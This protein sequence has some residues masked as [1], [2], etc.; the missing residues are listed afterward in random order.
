MFYLLSFLWLVS[1]TGSLLFWL[2]FW[3]LKEYHI[4]RALA[5][6]QTAKG[7]RIFW[8]PFLLFKIILAFTFFPLIFKP[9]SSCQA[10]SGNLI[11][12][13]T[14]I[15]LYF[16]ESFKRFFFDF[17]G[18]KLKTPVFTK[19]VV[20]LIFVIFSFQIFFVYFFL[21]RFTFSFSL[22]VFDILTPLIVSFFVFFFQPLAKAAKMILI[23]RAKQKRERLSDLVVI[24]ITGSY[25][26]T[27]TKEFLAKI[28][29]EKFGNEKVGKTKGHQNSEVGISRCLLNDIR[30]EH[31]FFVVE[32]GA[33]NRGGIKLLCDIAKPQIGILT[34]ISEQ[35]L[36]TFGSQENIIKTKFELIEALPESGTA[37]LNG[38]NRYIR[39]KIGSFLEEGKIKV[40]NKIFYST[41]ER[42]DVWAEEVRVGKKDLS[43]RVVTREG[44]RT[45]IKAAL[46][47]R[48][49]VENLL[50]AICAACQLKM[51]LKEISQA[52]ERIRVEDAG[53]RLLEGRF[54]ILDSSYSANPDGVIADLD[55]LTL[56]EG[57]RAI[58]MPSLI[59]LGRAARQVHWRIGKKIGRVCDLAIIT[60]RDYF[61]EIRRAAVTEGMASDKILCLESPSGILEKLRDFQGS[62]DIILIEGRVG[63]AIIDE[64]E[65]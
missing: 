38:D 11:L 10:Y 39:S 47:G 19:K 27:S 42:L 8:N 6:F 50:G 18:G 4:G 44:R 5:H 55:Y 57:K 45:D 9:S 16:L 36:A 40:K 60:T 65:R 43:F 61:E 30:P 7:S 31:K 29:S 46:I 34:G 53:V 58:I 35:H 64:L 24:A 28:L 41:K 59:E 1:E 2:Y 52:I 33:Y 3:Q 48:Q 14:L 56:W 22:L 62:N 23:R 17:L 37:I 20:F 15:V 63:R 21:K 13:G 32:M 26:K 54:N 51:N 12:G 49:N 25:G